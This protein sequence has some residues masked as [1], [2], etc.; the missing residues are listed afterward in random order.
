MSKASSQEEP[1]VAATLGNC[2]ELAE[3]IH[4]ISGSVQEGQAPEPPRP[5]MNL[6]DNVLTCERYAR[7]LEESLK[8]AL[9]TLSKLSRRLRY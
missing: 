3:N 9:A 8:A 6:Q 1:S 7:M 4:S 2:L 5:D